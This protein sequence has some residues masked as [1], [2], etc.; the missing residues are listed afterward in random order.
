MNV[1]VDRIEFKFL[2]RLSDRS[3]ANARL[4][5]NRALFEIGSDINRKMQYLDLAI[6]SIFA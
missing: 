2:K 1:Q 5:F 6:R 3:Q 4:G